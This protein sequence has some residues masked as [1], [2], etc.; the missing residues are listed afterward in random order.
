MSARALYAQSTKPMQPRDIPDG[1]WQ[2][3]I[4]DYLTHKGKDYLLICN[5]FSKNPF[6]YRVPTKSVQSLSMGLQELIS[7]Y[8]L[9]CMLYTDNGPLFASDE[10]TQFLQHYHIDHITSSPHFPRSSGFIECQVRTIKTALRTTKE[11]KKLLE[12]LLMDLQS[13]PIGPNMPSA[14]KIVYNRTFQCPGE[15]T[16]PVNME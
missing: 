10:L 16:T 8:E 5:L 13:T 3:I 15:K 9:P 1:P 12:D 11:S 4:A 14:W 7:Q 2:E 6:L